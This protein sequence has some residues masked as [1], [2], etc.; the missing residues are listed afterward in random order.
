MTT[1]NVSDVLAVEVQ[2]NSTWLTP[3][4]KPFDVLAGSRYGIPPTQNTLDVGSSTLPIPCMLK[5]GST[6]SEGH[7]VSVFIADTT[8]TPS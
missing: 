1:I 2:E 6:G 5:R 3:D 4:N 7:Y 8:R